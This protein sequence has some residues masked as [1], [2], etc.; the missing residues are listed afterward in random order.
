MQPVVYHAYKAA[1]LAGHAGASLRAC[2]G[3]GGGVY[4]CTHHYLPTTCLYGCAP[5]PVPAVLC[6]RYYR[7]RYCHLHPVPSFS[8]FLSR[9][10]P[11]RYSRR[12]AAPRRSSGLPHTYSHNPL[13]FCLHSCQLTRVRR[14]VLRIM[15]P[16][17]DMSPSLCRRLAV[18]RLTPPPP[19]ALGPVDPPTPVVA[20]CRTP[21]LTR[22][23]QLTR[24][25][26]LT[27][28][29]RTSHCHT[30]PAASYLLRGRTPT[31]YHTFIQTSA[32]LPCSREQRCSNISPRLATPHVRDE[33]RTPATAH[34]P[35]SRT[36][37]CDTP[38]LL[39]HRRSLPLTFPHV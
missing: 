18:R 33:L 25:F 36:L 9:Y 5:P 4:I 27:P 37:V 14:T 38:H 30:Q 28:F 24:T 22:C 32:I 2:C 3:G 20:G 26:F 31:N 29:C 39:Q 7:L 23:W 34:T 6:A 1:T 16:P 13:H 15:I 8:S 35:A 12:R 19:P 10:M 11:A 17:L 21:V